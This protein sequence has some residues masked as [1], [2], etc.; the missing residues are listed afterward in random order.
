MYTFLSFLQRHQEKSD[1]LS[2]QYEAILPAGDYEITF[3]DQDGVL[4]SSITPSDILIK[5]GDKPKCSAH[6]EAGDIGLKTEAPTVAPTTVLPEPLYSETILLPG[7]PIVKLGVHDFTKDP[8]SLISGYIAPYQI[9]QEFANPAFSVKPSQYT[10]S[11]I[12]SM[13]LYTSY[14]SLG[15]DPKSFILEG[16]SPNTSWNIIAEGPIDLPSGRNIQDESV[17]TALYLA[18][19]PLNNV[20]VYREYRLT[21]PTNGG[22]SWLALGQIQFTGFFTSCNYIMAE[23]SNSPTLNPSTSP[24]HAPTLNPSTSPSHSPQVTPQVDPP[25][26]AASL[27]EPTDNIV[28]LGTDSFTSEPYLAIDGLTTLYKIYKPDWTNP[29]FSVTPKQTSIVQEMRVYAYDG[30][31]KKDPREYKL[32]G[33][34]LQSNDWTLIKEGLLPSLGDRNTK[35]LPIDES[36]SYGKVSFSNTQPYN[37]YRLWF[38]SNRGNNYWI[39]VSEVSFGG[40]YVYSEDPLTTPY[41]KHAI[42]ESDSQCAS[43]VCA[44]GVC[45]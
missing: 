8:D 32:E 30:R 37:E 19:I 3:Y 11:I 33:R 1:D 27:L 17:S 41:P 23:P 21:F 45:D 2:S 43:G 34:L 44:A 14:R 24:S 29:A 7:D 39:I 5:L 6:L 4:D 38:P 15:R 25:L 12:Q 13:K 26:Y 22:S 36:T 28:K 16:Y 9:Y 10:C 40:F 18:T 42:C 35:D 20:N 31:S